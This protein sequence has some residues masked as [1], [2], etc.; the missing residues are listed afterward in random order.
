MG[1]E[2][3]MQYIMDGNGNYYTLNGNNQLVVARGREEAAVFT[4]YEANQRI[5]GG[6]KA[7]FYQTI[8]VAALDEIEGEMLGEQ[9]DEEM[10]DEDAEASAHTECSKV[11]SIVERIK[12]SSDMKEVLEPTKLQSKA[13]KSQP[14][15][16]YDI[17]AANWDEFINYFLFLVKSIKGY[18][19][20]LSKRHSDVE[21]EI[22]D[23]LHYVELYDLTDAEGIR[24]VEMLKDAR[25][26]RRDIKDEL[27]RIEYF[28]KTIGTSANEVK[29]RTFLTDIK[30]LDTRK[31]YPRQL[32]DLFDGM[33]KRQTDRRQYRERFTDRMKDVAREYVDSGETEEAEM[34]Y[35]ETI[36]DHKENDWLEFARQQKDFYQNVGQYM[37]N[38]QIDIDTINQAIEVI[39]ET[40]EDANYNVTQGYKV[41]KELKDLRN[42]RKA[43]EQEL[44]VLRTL[45]EGIDI[46]S[47]A[48]AFRIN[49]FPS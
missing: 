9:V 18:Q 36:F 34:E 23:L 5:G 30:K 4:F 16:E 22:C 21:K 11:Y 39:M 12:D 37:I 26:R 47:M 8:P 28:Q 32:S 10:A 48:D 46:D 1:N 49:P 31:Y 14:D 19:E 40:I 20:E 27:S 44:G 13:S 6:K 41:F 3:G 38:L 45:T 29:A 7:R 25:L 43:K 17:E 33:E 2:L 42:E 24:V 35:V 15:F